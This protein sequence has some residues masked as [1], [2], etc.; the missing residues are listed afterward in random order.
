MCTKS[1]KKNPDRKREGE[2][3]PHG[4]LGP[5]PDHMSDNAAAAWHEIA[6][7]APP[8]VL[9]VSD[10]LHL[11][12]TACLLAEYREDPQ[13]FPSGKLGVL[14]SCLGK[15]G[16]T[17]S[18]RASLSVPQRPEDNPYANLEQYLTKNYYYTTIIQTKHD[19]SMEQPNT[20]KTQTKQT[21]CNNSS[22]Q[23]LQCPLMV[24]KNNPQG[25]AKQ[26]SIF[27]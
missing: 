17:P 4:E 21:N 7:Y 9:W 2:P 15:M 22:K 12:I 26:Q 10:R 1:R 18:S 24:M 16:F 5:P 27:Y 11:E 3:I 8:G 20:P 19:S 13:R 14:N 23:L 25:T 6:H